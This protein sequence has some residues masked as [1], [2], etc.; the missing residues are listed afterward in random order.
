M[1]NTFELV[2]VN[3]MVGFVNLKEILPIINQVKVKTKNN[4]IIRG[5]WHKKR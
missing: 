5:K 1:K 2:G 3:M 4:D